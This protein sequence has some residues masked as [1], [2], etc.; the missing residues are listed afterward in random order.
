MIVNAERNLNAKF[1]Y[2]VEIKFADQLRGKVRLG[3]SDA[4]ILRFSSLPYAY[5]DV[6]K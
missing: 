3:S 4:P 1:A 2:L 5:L 6:T